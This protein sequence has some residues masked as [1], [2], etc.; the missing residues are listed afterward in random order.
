MYVE[1]VSVTY[2]VAL[3]SSIEEKKARMCVCFY[4]VHGGWNICC[5]KMCGGFIFHYYKNKK[6]QE[7]VRTCVCFFYAVSFLYLDCICVV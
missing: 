5:C 3:F 6:K 2:A 4:T 1:H 7:G